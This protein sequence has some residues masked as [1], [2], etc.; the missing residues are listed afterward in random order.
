MGEV[1]VDVGDG[2]EQRLAVLLRLVG[3][4]GRDLGVVEGVAEV[5]A[6]DGARMRT[7]SMTPLKVSSIPI[8]IWIGTGFT[9]RRSRIMS[10]SRQK[11]APVR[12]SLLMKQMRGTP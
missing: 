7:R 4:V 5:V 2:L 10:T 6:P 8:G 12:S 3:E 1:V 11:L 9:P